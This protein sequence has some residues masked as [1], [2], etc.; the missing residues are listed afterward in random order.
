MGALQ[1]IRMRTFT[2]DGCIKKHRVPSS[3]VGQQQR[4]PVTDRK[5]A[6]FRPGQG[7]AD[8]GDTRG[9]LAPDATKLARKSFRN[10]ENTHY[11]VSI[12]MNTIDPP[13][14]KRS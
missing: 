1:P 9:R 5:P 11:A 8:A 14:M 4:N 3:S 10:G 2:A 6:R 7:S 12:N 13:V